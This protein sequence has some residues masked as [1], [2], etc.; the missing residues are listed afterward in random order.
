MFCTNCGAS[1]KKDSK[2]CINCAESLSEAPV[3][4][5]LS[6]PRPVRHRSYLKKV[7]FLRPLFDLSFIQFASPRIVKFLYSLSIL[8]AV[9][10]ALLLIAIGFKASTWFG[11]LALLVGAP[12]ILLLTVISSRVFLEMILVISRTADRV[13]NIRLV[14]AEENPESRDDI[15]WNV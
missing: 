6:R 11:I 3:G 13:E 1:N 14:D 8:S 5:K 10:F 12:L 7:D 15:Q 9:L 2:F 4:E